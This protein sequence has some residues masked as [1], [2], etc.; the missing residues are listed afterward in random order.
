MRSASA[1]S[2][3]ILQI[4]WWDYRREWHN[5]PIK[6]FAWIHASDGWKFFKSKKKKITFSVGTSSHS[7]WYIHFKTQKNL[8]NHQNIHLLEWSLRAT[9]SYSKTELTQE[10]RRMRVAD[11]FWGLHCKYFWSNL[12]VCKKQG[13]EK[14]KL[15][16]AAFTLTQGELKLFFKKSD[17]GLRTL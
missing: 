5:F 4:M 11:G 14:N 13:T 12:W 6:S 16:F 9:F 2:V 17:T 7:H 3:V 1:C 10:N 15:A 8:E